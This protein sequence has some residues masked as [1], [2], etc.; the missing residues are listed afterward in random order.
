MSVSSIHSKLLENL[1]EGVYFVDVERRISFWNRAAEELTGFKREDILSRVCAEGTLCHTDQ[2]GKFLC[3]DGCPLQATLDD[4]KSRESEV[5]LQHKEG[6]RVPVHVRVAPVHDDQGNIVGAMEMFRHAQNEIDQREQLKTLENL[7]NADALTELPNRRHILN[8]LESRLEELKRYKWPFGVLFMD[9]DFFKQVNDVHGHDVGDEVLKMVA[10]S[11]KG[12]I[13]T[14]DVV[15]RYGGEEFIAIIANVD[16]AQLEIIG[17]RF[18]MI[19]E[20]S[21]IR[22]ENPLSV[23]I[24]IGAAIASPDENGESLLK[25]ADQNLYKSKENGRNRLTI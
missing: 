1:F 15:G 25:R 8:S 14:F 22:G 5:F 23:T 9:I 20:R 6:H 18:R 3:H 19:V 10:K 11:L 13:R 4:G 7:A 12:A 2:N 24:S 17:N 21:S 16:K